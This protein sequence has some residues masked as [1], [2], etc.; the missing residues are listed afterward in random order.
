MDGDWECTNAGCTYTAYNN[1]QEFYGITDA[2]LSTPT[3]VRSTPIPIAG[4]DPP[5]NVVVSEWWELRET[6]LGLKTSEHLVVNYMRMY[7]SFLPGASEELYTLVLND[8]DPDY[9]TIDNSNDIYL[10]NGEWTDEFGR[11]WGSDRYHIPN[12]GLD[13]KVWGW[14]RMDMDDDMIAE[15]TDPLN[16]DTDGDWMNDW[17]EIDTDMLDNIRG[18]GPSPL[19][20]DYRI[21]NIG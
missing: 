5:I 10:V 8:M 4:T 7:R 21:T 20:W 11:M 9:M 17:F 19:R 13:E 6:L 14:W 15:G 2:S 3:A 18:Y 1:F 12:M 16:W